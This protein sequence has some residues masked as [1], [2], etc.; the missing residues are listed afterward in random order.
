VRRDAEVLNESLPAVALQA[1]TARQKRL[2]EVA[3]GS[4]SLGVQIRR[5]GS[6]A[7]TVAPARPA[8]RQPRAEPSQTYDVAL[9]FAG[10]QRAY[11]EQVAT[12]LRDAGVSVF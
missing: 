3:Q 4:A 1:V 12:G 7:P 9:S 10:E 2:S 5:P 8:A 6:A 11:V